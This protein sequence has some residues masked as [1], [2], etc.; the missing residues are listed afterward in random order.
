M[1]KA[2]VRNVTNSETMQCDKSKRT[3]NRRLIYKKKQ[4]H[5]KT[6]TKKEKVH[7]I[8]TMALNKRWGTPHGYNNKENI[9]WMKLG[10]KRS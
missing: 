1:T 7:I 3:K 5:N 6:N 2:K 10:K 8:M 4:K 9:I